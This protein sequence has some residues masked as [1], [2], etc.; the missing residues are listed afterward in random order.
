[1]LYVRT[2]SLPSAIAGVPL[3]PSPQIVDSNRLP[4]QGEET[5]ILKENVSVLSVA[6]RTTEEP[7]CMRLD[8]GNPGNLF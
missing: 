4:L 1:M 3:R 2:Y 6:S 8:F 7:G 5:E